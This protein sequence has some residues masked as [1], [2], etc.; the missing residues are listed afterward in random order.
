MPRWGYTD[1]YILVQKYVLW[2]L[3]VSKAHL[4]FRIAS[5]DLDTEEGIR[6]N[7][8]LDEGWRTWTCHK[9]QQRWAV[10]RKSVHSP[11]VT[12]RGE[13]SVQ[14]LSHQSAYR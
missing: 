6:W 2:P 5:L 12:H 3:T 11:G 4:L 7:T 1:S 8:L 10:L 9:L 14:C 13:Y